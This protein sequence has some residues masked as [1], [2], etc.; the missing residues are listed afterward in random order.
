MLAVFFKARASTTTSVPATQVPPTAAHDLAAVVGEL[1]EIVKSALVASATK[2]NRTLPSPVQLRGSFST[3]A[4]VVAAL[5]AFSPVLVST[6]TAKC[7]ISPTLLVGSRF[8]VAL[9]NL[10][11]D[12]MV[13]A[14]AVE[15]AV[16]V[17]VGVG[18]IVGVGDGVAVT[19]LA[20]MLGLPTRYAGETID[21]AHTAVAAVT[22]KTNMTA[23][24]TDGR[25]ALRTAEPTAAARSCHLCQRWFTCSA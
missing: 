13:V 19:E 11:E 7:L 6:R 5:F 16:G 14:L 3:A 9:A 12:A 23:N 1:N 24:N 10:P 18:V 25:S 2:A 21:F 8:K 17:S 22:P 15:V 20:A 4:M